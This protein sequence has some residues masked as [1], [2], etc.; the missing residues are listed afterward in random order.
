[1]Y[2][3][4]YMYYYNISYYHPHIYV[5]TLNRPVRVYAMTAFMYISLITYK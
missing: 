4:L 1:M 2:Y 5:Y 3:I